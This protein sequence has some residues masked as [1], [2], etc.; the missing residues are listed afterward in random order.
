MTAGNHPARK[1]WTLPPG[2]AVTLVRGK[3]II[4]TWLAAI[5]AQI[6]VGYE[7]EAGFHVGMKMPPELS[8]SKLK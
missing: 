2:Y 3:R 1:R 6:P 5:A 8:G 7:D 4:A